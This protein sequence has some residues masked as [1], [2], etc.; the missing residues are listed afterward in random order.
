M[1]P[2]LAYQHALDLCMVTAGAAPAQAVAIIAQQDFYH[3]AFALR[4]PHVPISPIGTSAAPRLIWAEPE[5]P[6]AAAVLAQLSQPGVAQQLCIITSNRLARRLPEWH[7]AA[8]APAHAPLGITGT[9]RLLR[10]T[11]WQV[12]QVFGFHA[13]VSIIYGIIGQVWDRLHRHDL[14]DRWHFRMRAAY[15][16][17]GWQARL[18]PVSVVI[19]HR[20]PSKKANHEEHAE[21]EAKLG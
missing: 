18:A 5:Q 11:V 21:H 14:A 7:A 10:G 12:T 8:S 16:Q 3:A 15:V 1:Y 20:C 19:A 6:T 2:S 13:G 4:L 17:H 9:L